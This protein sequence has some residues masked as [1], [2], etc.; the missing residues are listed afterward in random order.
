MSVIEAAEITVSFSPSFLP[1]SQG[2][3]GLQRSRAL[4]PWLAQRRKARSSWRVAPPRS[5]V[6]L[7]QAPC[8]R[9]PLEPLLTPQAEAE[10][11]PRPASGLWFRSLKSSTWT[12]WFC[13]SAG[14]EPVAGL[15]GPRNQE[16]LPTNSPLC[17]SSHSLPSILVAPLN[18]LALEAEGDDGVFSDSR[19]K[20]LPL[21]GTGR[22]LCARVCVYVCVQQTVGLSVGSSPPGTRDRS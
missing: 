22:T 13:W 17:S 10:A 11:R 3:R 16:R 12:E 18:P 9:C 4:T 14:A 8:W 19:L 21:Y 2:L 20:G 6:A 7:S 1:S 15:D 5:L